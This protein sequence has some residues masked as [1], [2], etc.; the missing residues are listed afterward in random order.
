MPGRGRSAHQWGAALL[1][2]GSATIGLAASDALAQ[3][4][5][6]F[7]FGPVVESVAGRATVETNTG[8]V[9]VQADPAT[10]YER[11]GLGTL[12][13][14][15]P[16]QLVGVTARLID[17]GFQALEV[18]IFPAG[19]TSVPQGQTAMS[20]ANAGNSM[21]NARVEDFTNGLLTLSFGEQRFSIN[22][23]PATVVRRPEAA[24]AAEVH[25]GTRIA[26]TG[27]PDPAGVLQ[28]VAVFI[29]APSGQ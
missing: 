3:D 4:T 24:S 19:L 11:D 20:G 16:G 26:V 7:I 6:Q 10:V 1:L 2:A 15:Q 21:I 27:N 25:E 18:R 8:P 9:A 23:S 22:T 5:A 17:T 14:I 12:E 13:D 28:A 29:L